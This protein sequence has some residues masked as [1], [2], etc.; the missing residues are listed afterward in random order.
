LRVA[1]EGFNKHVPIDERKV[2]ALSMFA[3]LSRKKALKQRLRFSSATADGP[4]DNAFKH[5]P[6][7]EQL[8]A[9]SG[10]VRSQIPGHDPAHEVLPTLADEWFRR[11]DA[12]Y[13]VT[14]WYTA[15]KQNA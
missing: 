10:I 2:D 11:Y 15:D 8:A 4:F 7:R 6:I 3:L 9:L 13:D 1:C 5:L 12:G 14:Q